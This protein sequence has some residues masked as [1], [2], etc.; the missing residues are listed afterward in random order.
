M[1]YLLEEDSLRG[2]AVMTEDGPEV[3]AKLRKGI[4]RDLY[5]RDH[6]LVPDDVQS[7]APADVPMPP[8]SRKPKPYIP[9]TD[10]TGDDALPYGNVVGAPLG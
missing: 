9:P 10:F 4:Y 5:G 6:G 8:V 7:D 3:V 1:H 2:L